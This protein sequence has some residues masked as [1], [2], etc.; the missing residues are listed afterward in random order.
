MELTLDRVLALVGIILTVVLL[1]LDKAEKLK[2][3]AVFYLL[4]L[5]AAMTVP[6]ALSNPWVSGQTGTPLIV[7]RIFA[8]AIVAAV[9]SGIGSW[10]AGS[11]PET[12]KKEEVQRPESGEPGFM[13]V[14]EVSLISK[15]IKAGGRLMFRVW[16]VNKGDSPYGIYF[17]TPIYRSFEE[18]ET[19]SPTRKS[20]RTF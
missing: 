7:R 13:Q 8:M 10:V 3:A 4:I 20:T 9:Y 2:G 19:A 5:A 14:G 1:A 15:E 17:S 12:R 18:G 16:L 11:S 6:L